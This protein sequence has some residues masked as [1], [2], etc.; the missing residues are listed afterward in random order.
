[1]GDPSLD[2]AMRN[3]HAVAQAGWAQALAGKQAVGDQGPG[4]A[5]LALKQQPG[6]FKPAFCWWHQRSRALGRRAIWKLSRI[7][8]QWKWG[9]LCTPVE[10]LKVYLSAT[11]TATG[12]LL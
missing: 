5:V 9:R 11:K 10:T 12:R 6:L 3:S 4:Q 7:H 8:G 1:M 2:A